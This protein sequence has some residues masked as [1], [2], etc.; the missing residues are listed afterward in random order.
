[1]GLMNEAASTLC[2]RLGSTVEAGEMV[3]I[4]RLLGDMTIDVI[5]AAAFG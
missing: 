3:D 2:Q 5:G 1:M 4:W